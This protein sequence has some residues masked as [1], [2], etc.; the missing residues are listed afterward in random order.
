MIWTH[1]GRWSDDGL[2]VLNCYGL[3]CYELPVRA[4][5]P[6][7]SYDPQPPVQPPSRKQEVEISPQS[8]SSRFSSCTEIGSYQPERV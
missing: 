2:T 3:V 7:S 8:G 4:G 6:P 1:Y 5:R